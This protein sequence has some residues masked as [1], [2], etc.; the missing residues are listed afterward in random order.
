MPTRSL[1]RLA[2]IVALLLGSVAPRGAAQE[3]PERPEPI[4]PRD[5]V[6]KLFNGRDLSGLYVFM[7]DTGYDDPRRVFRVEDGLLHVTGDGFG[8]LCTEKEYRD[9]HMICEFRWGERTWGKREKAARDS[10]VLVHGTGPDGAYGG[11]WMASIEAQIIEGG[12]GDIIVVPGKDAQGEPIPLALTAEVREDR[13]G[14]P[15]WHPGGEPRVFT[16]GRINWS[17]RDS[18]W[19]DTIGFRGAND[20]ESPF[21]E[22]TRMDVICDADRITI[23]VNGVVVNGGR[24]AVPTAGK[25]TIQTELAEIFIRRWELWPLGKAPGAP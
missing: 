25:L 24:D 5:D 10:G 17:G 1:R 4:S 11:I 13:D 22:W 23:L 14:E 12:V 7:Q 16:R 9:Y 2:L 20:V 21:G 3:V 15:V 18:D 8:G 19:K 6:V